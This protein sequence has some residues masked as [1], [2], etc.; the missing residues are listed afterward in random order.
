MQTNPDSANRGA[1]PRF[2]LEDDGDITT[3]ILAGRR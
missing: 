3:I 1:E 2:Q